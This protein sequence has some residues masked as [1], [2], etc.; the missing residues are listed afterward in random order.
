MGWMSLVC[1]CKI[2]IDDAKNKHDVD[3]GTW[4]WLMC[5]HTL[6]NKIKVTHKTISDKTI[7]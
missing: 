5:S 7:L 6:K 1:F 4:P 3:E 2:S